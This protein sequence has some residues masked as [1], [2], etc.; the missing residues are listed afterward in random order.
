MNARD[1]AKLHLGNTGL[2][3]HI[4]LVQ[5]CLKDTINS[6]E[7]AARGLIP[8]YSIEMT[9]KGLL[10]NEDEALN[11][12]LT[13]IKKDKIKPIKLTVIIIGSGLLLFL[14]LFLYKKKIPNK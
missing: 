6:E 3:L 1:F 10:Y 12:V 2:T 14:S 5:I 13:L 11:F 7:S 9:A 8:D 4:P